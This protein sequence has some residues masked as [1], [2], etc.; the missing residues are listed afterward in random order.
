MGPIQDNRTEYTTGTPVETG[1]GD[2]VNTLQDRD[3]VQVDLHHSD[4]M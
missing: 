2:T 4:T 3:S 1:D